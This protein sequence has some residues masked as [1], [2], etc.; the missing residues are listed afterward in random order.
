MNQKACPPRQFRPSQLA[1]RT[2]GQCLPDRARG[3]FYRCRKDAPKIHIAKMCRT[4][5]AVRNRACSV[6]AEATFCPGM[7]H[8]Y[9]RMSVS[10]IVGWPVLP[11]DTVYERRRTRIQGVR[12]PTD[13]T[14]RRRCW[15]AS[16]LSPRTSCPTV[17]AKDH[18]PTGGPLCRSGS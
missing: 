3:N 7:T 17:I 13:G 6:R 8:S 4:A 12:D 15:R 10:R 5:E 9:S 18:S 11:L 2:C 14:Y 1:W 16:S